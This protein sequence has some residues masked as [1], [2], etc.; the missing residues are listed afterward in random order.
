MQQQIQ[1]Q[2]QQKMQMETMKD[3]ISIAQEKARLDG[4]EMDNKKKA[5]EIDK[6]IA[7]LSGAS[8]ERARTMP[9]RLPVG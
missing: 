6:M 3:Q 2:A 5:L 8:P 4:I 1:Q 9:E 7:E